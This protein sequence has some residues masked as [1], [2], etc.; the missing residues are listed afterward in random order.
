MG[1]LVFF[2][3]IFLFISFS[4]LKAQKKD[5]LLYLLKTASGKEKVEILNELTISLWLNYPDESMTYAREAL[6]LSRK[7]GDHY[8]LAKSLRLVG[9]VHY[10]K[11]NYDSAITYNRQSLNIAT[12][13]GEPELTNNALNNIGLLYYS[14]GSY[15]HAL[16]NLLRSL[17]I[18]NRIGATYGKG[19]TLNNIGLVYSKLKDYQQ[20][21]NY[22]FQ[23]L[24]FGKEHNDLNVVLYSQNNIGQTFLDED[25]I[26][27]AEEYFKLSL[28]LPVNNTNWKATAY[29]GLGKVEQKKG[30]YDKAEDY[31]KTALELRETIGDKQG[32]S[33]IYYFL[34][35]AEAEKGAIKEAI[36]FLNISHQIARDINAKDR[37]LENYSFF[38]KLYESIG[39]LPRAYLY[40]TR[41]L[42]LRD[43]LFN[44]NLARNL[45][46][47]QL[48][49]QEEESN[50]IISEKDAQIA[51]NKSLTISLIVVVILSIALTS[52]IYYAYRNNKNINKLL[53][54]RNQKI[55]SQK[56][57]IEDQKEELIQN[58]HQL[59]KAQRIIQDQNDKLETL[60]AKLKT[61][62]DRR[63]QQLELANRDLKRANLELDNFIYKSS[64]DIRGPLATLMGIC[65]VALMEVE[66]EKSKNYFLMLKQTSDNLNA[67][68]NRLKTISDINSHVITKQ[69]VNFNNIIKRCFDHIRTLEG[70]LDFQVRKEIARDIDLRSDPALLDIIFFNLIQN[71]IHFK[72]PE[73]P[74]N[75]IDIRIYQ[76]A[77]QLYIEFMDNGIGIKQSESKD[78]FEM[79]S[80]AANK[81]QNVGLGLYIVKQCAQKLGGNIILADDQEMT[82]FILNLPLAEVTEEKVNV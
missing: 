23:A 44:E 40:Q 50:R 70:N 64:H 48:K 10:Y 30:N 11:G 51:Q 16:E 82:H 76:D 71:A 79:F 15:Q 45:A 35:K 69:P 5:S 39:E 46:A 55:L 34:S 21:R 22:F 63:T 26:T 61:K 78:I 2:L 68:L 77:D 8:S 25:N 9:A 36:D 38:S 29:T 52:L 80:K 66:N 49:V 62:V 7:I 73:E 32:I 43:S 13:I 75:I 54:E 57:E 24:Q 1:R 6:E 67:I 17:N 37:I 19:T 58:N 42:N 33:E 59:Q 41:F 4:S 27:T 14:V 65:N 60:N 74:E 56:N 12:S 20:A 3:G 31:L 18:K 81:H 28:D 53:A 47:I 72:D